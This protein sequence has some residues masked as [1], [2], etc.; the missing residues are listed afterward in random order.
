MLN[1]LKSQTFSNQDIF[2]NNY[3]SKS[4]TEGHDHG[5]M[6]LQERLNVSDQLNRIEYLKN[7]QVTKTE[8][9]PVEKP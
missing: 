6:T 8:N 3:Q 1:D 7:R 2:S 9:P 5:Q 4:N